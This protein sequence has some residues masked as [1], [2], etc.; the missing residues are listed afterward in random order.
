MKEL[1]KKLFDIVMNRSD[2]DAKA[3]IGICCP[4]IPGE[5]DN[6]GDEVPDLNVLDEN[7]STLLHHAVRRGLEWTVGRLLDKGAS[8]DIKDSE[9]I[10]PLIMSART[11]H[12][13]SQHSVPGIIRILIEGGAN[14]NSTE[15]DGRTFLQ[16]AVTCGHGVIVDYMLNQVK[17][18]PNFQNLKTGMTAL[19]YAALDNQADLI[20]M[21]FRAGARPD[22]TSTA[23]YTPLKI[24][25]KMKN[26][27]TATALEKGVAPSI[28]K[29]REDSLAS[30]LS[31]AFFAQKGH[32]KVDAHVEEEGKTSRRSPGPRVDD[33]D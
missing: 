6:P 10:T 24:A 16:I 32:R 8:V 4:L 33:L 21:L 7:G 18:D 12:G 25:Q 9:G 15:N 20:P 28:P 1:E 22:I 30:V 19:H 5:P 29:Q 31:M 17:T 3:G 27:E 26:Y 13:H 11:L 23:G 2:L 14:I